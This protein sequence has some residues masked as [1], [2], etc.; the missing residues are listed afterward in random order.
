MSL[1]DSG[2]RGWQ[3]W[4]SGRRSKFLVAILFIL[5]A[6]GL[7]SQSGKLA[8]VQKSDTADFLPGGAESVQALE[9][10]RE[11]P[12]GQTAPAVVIIAARVAIRGVPPS[13]VR[14]A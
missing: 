7:S 11:F 1:P 8:E 12:S 10:A 13:I 6:G 4:I 3:A 9:A 5:V 2:A 14:T